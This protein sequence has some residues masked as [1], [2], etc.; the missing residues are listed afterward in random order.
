[1]PE[2]MLRWYPDGGL[3]G[4]GRVSADHPE[5]WL[6]WHFT[7]ISN[8]DL[9]LEED[10]LLPSAIARPLTNVGQLSIKQSRKSEPVR[11]PARA[12][13]PSVVADHIPL[14]F[15][16]KSPMLFKVCRGHADYQGGAGPLVFLGFRVGDI[17][18]AGC[19]WCATNAN[20]ATSW[21]EYTQD[22]EGLGDFVD[23]EV[24]TARI[25]KRTPEEPDRPSRRAAELLVRDRLPLDLL[26]LVVTQNGPT[27]HEVSARLASVGLQRSV[28]V[29]PDMYY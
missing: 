5:D 25:W 22:L 18:D 29:R 4:I 23:F 11:L 21:A 20:A 19:T 9:I 10:A 17:V 28:M 8:L 7:H 24:L 6:A 13:P 2:E 12:Y 26:G 16:A 1:M 3:V 14:Y 27:S 15:A